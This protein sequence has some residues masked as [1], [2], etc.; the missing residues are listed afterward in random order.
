VL[1]FKK[2]FNRGQAGAGRGT[3]GGMYECFIQKIGGLNY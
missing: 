1:E 3:G 2:I